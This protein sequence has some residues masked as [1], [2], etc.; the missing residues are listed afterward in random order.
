M[1]GQSGLAGVGRGSC[2]LC[3]CSSRSI[4]LD[5][6][7]FDLR[8]AVLAAQ[9]R[10]SEQQQRRRPADPDQTRDRVPRCC[11]CILVVVASSAV[12]SARRRAAKMHKRFA[13]A[14][15]L[16]EGPTRK[17]QKPLT[18]TN[19]RS[20]FCLVR[21]DRRNRE[22]RACS[23]SIYDATTDKTR[24]FRLVW[25]VVWPAFAAFAAAPPALPLLVAFVL[26]SALRGYGMGTAETFWRR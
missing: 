13:S 8:L 24:P 21:R 7:N 18:K 10:R 22:L 12:E 9:D 5:W 6:H 16:E 11:R 1:E 15:K 19:G 14:C 25:A 20:I 4:L 3:A 17:K 23:V 2:W 26:A